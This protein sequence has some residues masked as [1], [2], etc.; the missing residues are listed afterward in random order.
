MTDTDFGL[1]GAARA[2]NDL[3]NGLGRQ[4]ANVLIEAFGQ[5]GESISLL[6]GWAARN[7]E[8]DFQK[9]SESILRSNP[10]RSVSASFKFAPGTDE[11]ATLGQS[12]A[13]AAMLGR[14][15][16]GQRRFL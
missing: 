12:S 16:Q 5:V 1:D 3:A 7:G 2:F 10:G 11:R 8:F 9:M 15:V 14:L 13:V 4:A 6:L